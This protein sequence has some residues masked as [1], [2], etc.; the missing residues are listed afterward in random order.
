MLETLTIQGEQVALLRDGEDDSLCVPERP[1]GG[2]MQAQTLA[3]ARHILPLFMPTAEIHSYSG[4]ENTA[5]IDLA[6]AGKLEQ[7]D[8]KFLEPLARVVAYSSGESCGIFCDEDCVASSP[9]PPVGIYLPGAAPRPLRNEAE[10]TVAAR[11]IIRAA[12]AGVNEELSEVDPGP[13]T[14]LSEALQRLSCRYPL[15][16]PRVDCRG[17]LVELQIANPLPEL[18]SRWMM[19]LLVDLKRLEDQHPPCRCQLSFHADPAHELIRLLGKQVSWNL[20]REG[21]ES[22]ELSIA[23][24]Q[25]VQSELC[26]DQIART[27]AAGSGCNVTCT[28][29]VSVEAPEEGRLIR[30]Y[31][32]LVPTGR[33]IER[34]R[35]SLAARLPA[36]CAPDGE[37]DV[38]SDTLAVSF[39]RALPANVVSWICSDFESHGLPV[40]I[41]FN[42][43]DMPIVPPDVG[44]A[45]QIIR[46]CLPSRH[47]LKELPCST[48]GDEVNL[49]VV[50]LAGRRSAL[51]DL[52][53]PLSDLSQLLHAERVSIAVRE[54]GVEFAALLQRLMQEG[55]QSFV[56]Y[57]LLT[58]ELDGSTRVDDTDLERAFRYAYPHASPALPAALDFDPGARSNLIQE[59]VFRLPAPEGSDPFVWFSVRAAGGNPP[60]LLVHFF[61]Y[62]TMCAAGSAIDRFSAEQ[63]SSRGTGPAG[64]ADSLCQLAVTLIKEAEVETGIPV[65]TAA[66][67][68]SKAS[69]SPPVVFRSLINAGEVVS[70]NQQGQGGAVARRAGQYNLFRTF[71]GALQGTSRLD[72]RVLRSVALQFGQATIESFL[73]EK[74][75]PYLGQRSEGQMPGLSPVRNT[76]ASPAL[77]GDD[78][79]ALRRLQQICG[80][81]DG[82]VFFSNNSLSKDQR[83]QRAAAALMEARQRVLSD[84]ELFEG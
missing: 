25:E 69:S 9:A 54:P 70:G 22:S 14:Q 45:D 30:G 74:G 83:R 43:A 48:A 64:R 81:L 84:S 16:E 62:T 12:G 21:D 42:P 20:S 35:E 52:E 77:A 53:G 51:A 59:S 50:S 8:E 1:S 49:E 60:E 19:D 39:P 67:P 80:A 5:R 76:A 58:R 2:M 6:L 26:P 65:I 38:I 75:I 63:Y 72:D 78:H 27:V 7:S 24:A 15:L 44:A 29:E 46:H 37:S 33:I 32:P 68:L 18:G 41:R 11:Q 55:D 13:V 23:F 79:L 31:R 56:E 40:P 36:F 57:L 3:I 28:G 17:E 10:L 4:S 66:I 47:F 71:I 61:D 73:S 34:A 82:H